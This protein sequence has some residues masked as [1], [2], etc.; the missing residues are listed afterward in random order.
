MSERSGSLAD[1]PLRGRQP[2]SHERMAGRPWD[3]S[4]HDGPVPWDIVR[5][6]A[7][8]VR[9]ASKGAFA[10]AVLDAG[11]GSEENALHLASLG[12][13]VLGV[14]VAVTEVRFRNREAVSKPLTSRAKKFRES[15]LSIPPPHD[16]HGCSSFV[17]LNQGVRRGGRR[18][19]RTLR[20]PLPLQ[21]K[22][23]PT[24]RASAFAS[25]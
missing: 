4:Y 11:C 15:R 21:F 10:G 13:S 1:D 23:N 16:K 17:I 24:Q 9:L 8:L 6:Q 22:T 25:A 2:T 7:A 5:P 18:R 12:L 14:D 20:L 3:A 19:R